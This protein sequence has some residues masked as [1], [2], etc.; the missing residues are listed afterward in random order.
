MRR[1]SPEAGFT[2]IEMMVSMMIMMVVTGALFHMV[3]DANSGFRTQPE[4]ADMQ[5]RLRVAADM[6]YKDLL[7]AGAGPD[8]AATLGSLGNYLPS[9][10]P[11]RRGTLNPDGALTFSPNRI[12]I[13]YVPRTRAQTRLAFDMGSAAGDLTIDTAAPGCPGGSPCG[14]SVGSRALLFDPSAAGAG[15]ELFTVTGTGIA[16]LEHA[17]PNRAF[18]RLYT[19]NAPVTE[20]EEHIY[21]LDTNTRRLMHYDGGQG[22]SPLVDNV[23]ALNFTYYVDPNPNSAPRPADGLAN[24]LYDAGSPPVPKLADLGGTALVRLTAGQLTDGPTCGVGENQFDGDLLRVRKVRVTI[25]VQAGLASLRGG[26]SKTFANAGDSSQ[27][28]TMVP[29]YRV[30]FEVAPRNLNLIR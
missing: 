12:S 18:T 19:A 3:G 17:A 14:F 7:M 22:D 16:T 25:G 29:D 2:L 30:S 6:I 20:V 11:A 5:Q 4:T 21:Y 8:Q 13:V 23:V 24:C 15:Y 1:R 26:D 9:I 27:A 28:T 10:R